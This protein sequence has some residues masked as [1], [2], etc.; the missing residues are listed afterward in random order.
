MTTVV[1]LS[2]APVRVA[3]LPTSAPSACD[4]M[5]KTGGVLSLTVT[6]TFLDAD[7]DVLPKES[8][9]TPAAT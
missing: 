5:V 3:A 2:H 1:P 4:V 8:V 7:S 6:E 9:A